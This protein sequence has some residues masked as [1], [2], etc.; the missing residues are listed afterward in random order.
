LK[1]IEGTTTTN[2]KTNYK[3]SLA[4]ESSFRTLYQEALKDIHRLETNVAVLETEREQVTSNV[5]T[6]AE[7]L[8]YDLQKKEAIIAKQA[9]EIEILKARLRLYQSPR[10]TPISSRSDDLV[11]DDHEGKWIR[12]ET[13]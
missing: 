12:P 11:W 5:L 2:L 13:I 3:M 4:I 7:A 8:V 9:K 10:I 6:S 1:F